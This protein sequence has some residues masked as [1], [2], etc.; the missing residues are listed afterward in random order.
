[1]SLYKGTTLISGIVPDMANQS[2]SNLNSTGQAIID[3]KVSKTGDTMTDAL[4]FKDANIELGVIPTTNKYSRAIYIRDKN[5][6]EI[7]QI[8]YRQGSDNT[9]RLTLKVVSN[10]G[11]DAAYAYVGYDENGV[12]DFAF[13]NT[14]R[15]DGQWVKKV[16]VLADYVTAPTTTDLTY[17]LSSY[18]PNDSYKYE[19]LLWGRVATGT[20]SGN[21]SVLN[22][23]SDLASL[24]VCEAR[25]RANAGTEVAAAAIIPVN[26]KTL[27]ILALSGN[28]GTVYLSLQGYRRIG[29]N[30]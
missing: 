13:P 3:G 20:T 8:Y 2:L 26:A 14:N 11:T 4:N 30:A 29:T 17:S 15:I 19:I 22:I 7:A 16:T 12:A 10:N 28:T 21:R 9:Q 5:D 18:L 1:M 25:T 6:A 24:R 23:Q 27:S